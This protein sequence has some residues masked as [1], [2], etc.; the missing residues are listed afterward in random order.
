M[1][2]HFVKEMVENEKVLLKEVD[3]IENV[4]DLLNKFVST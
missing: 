2:Y 4:A 3:T 1:Q